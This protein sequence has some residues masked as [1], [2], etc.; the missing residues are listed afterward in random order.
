MGTTT[1]TNKNLQKALN[2]MQKRYRTAFYSLETGSK[3]LGET[4]AKELKTEISTNYDLFI[5]SLSHDHQDH[6]YH[7]DIVPRSKEGYDVQIIGMQVIYD[8]FGT[9]IVGLQNPHPVKSNHNLNEYNTGPSIHHFPDSNKD[10]WVYFS[11]K[12]GRWATSHG[13]P[14]G[15]FVY[16]SISNMAD[17]IWIN[18]YYKEVFGDLLKLDKK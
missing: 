11:P 15:Q 16:D 9:G 1:S 6:T 12:D 17:G 3:Y 7:I 13:V 10:Y 8:E 18:N 14:S 2:T 4:E 5:N